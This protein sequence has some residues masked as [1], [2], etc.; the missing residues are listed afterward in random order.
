M[1]SYQKHLGQYFTVNPILKR[2][3]YEFIKNHADCILEP[4]CGRGDLVL[5]VLKMR[6]DQEFHLYEIDTNITLLAPLTDEMVNWGD[7]LE[8][9]KTRK[10]ATIIGNPPYVR[11]QNID[12]NSRV[13]FSHK[14]TT[15]YQNYDLYVLFTEKI[16]ALINSN[17]RAGYIMPK[18]FITSEYGEPLKKF[19]YDGK[20]LESFVDFSDV[21]IFED[22]TTYTGMFFFKKGQ[23]AYFDYKK[24]IKDPQKSLFDNPFLQ[25][26]YSNLETKNWIFLNQIESN[27]FDR[28]SGFQKLKD[29]DCSMFVGLQ[30]SADPVFIIEKR[31]DT[32]YSNFTK[33]EYYFKDF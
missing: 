18:K 9:E 4:S 8:V 12:I 23:E 31:G 11:M 29:T 32:F 15:A 20:L 3:V 27:L 26:K 21:Q 33:K 7:F 14:Y 22:A 6:P 10:Y 17:G 1:S 13:Y 2:K 28:L 19:I 25:I 24:I 16:P 30:T 5:E